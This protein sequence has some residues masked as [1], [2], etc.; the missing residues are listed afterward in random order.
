MLVPK[1]G[2]Y[3]A[4]SPAYGQLAE[5]AGKLQMLCRMLVHK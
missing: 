1:K 5:A 4:P 3:L 2:L